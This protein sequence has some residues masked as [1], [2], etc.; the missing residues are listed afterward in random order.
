[1]KMYAESI[2][3]SQT[4]R[5]ILNFLLVTCGTLA[6]LYVLLLGSI[7]WNIVERRALETQ[8]RALSNEVG[9]LELVYLGALQKINPAYS[10]SLGFKEVKAKFVTRGSALRLTENT[11]TQN[12]I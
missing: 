2:S 10:A 12:E 4:R 3:D 8:A 9:E 7:V 1:M 6:L 5:Q 11:L